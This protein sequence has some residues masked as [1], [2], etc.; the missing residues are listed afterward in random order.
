M[1]RV[2]H[3]NGG[4]LGVPAICFRGNITVTAATSEVRTAAAW[5]GPG[6]RA[7]V[8]RGASV[9]AE[10]YQV[11]T[12][13]CVHD[14]AMKQAWCLAT[15]TTDATA[16][17]LMSL[18]GKRC[19][20]ESTFRDAEDRRFGM[21]MG[22]VR[23]STPD[24]RDRLRRLNAL[25]SAP[26]LHA[27]RTHPHHATAPAAAAGRAVRGHD[28]R[29]SGLCPYS[30]TH[31]KMMRTLNHYE[32]FTFHCSPDLVEN[33]TTASWGPSCHGLQSAAASSL[34]NSWQGVAGCRPF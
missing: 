8:L 20:I 5:V 15:S 19:S 22:S 21:G 14:R 30:L 3:G 1:H 11:G 2:I 7:C 32:R 10:R 18:D 29:A 4:Y 25:A 26:R 6:G 27:L 12:V 28:R 33:A 31:L 34:A 23:V 24:R 9:T 16:K 13:L 17:A